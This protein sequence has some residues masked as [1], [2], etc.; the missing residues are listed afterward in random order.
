[1][2]RER[3]IDLTSLPPN[4]WKQ[5]IKD[6]TD[7]DSIFINGSIVNKIYMSSAYFYIGWNA[8]RKLFDNVKVRTAMTHAFNR[9]EIIENVYYGLGEIITGPFWI[10]SPEYDHNIKHYEFN[11]QKAEKLLEEAG[12]ILK[13]G[14]TKRTKI[15]DGEEKEFEFTVLLPQGSQERETALK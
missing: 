9:M 3:K 11:L 7:S 5:F 12:W 8:D 15:I 13:A 4:K 6:N 1:M 14:N 10:E 2:F